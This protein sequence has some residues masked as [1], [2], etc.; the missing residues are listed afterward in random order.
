M[1]GPGDAHSMAP[2][3]RPLHWLLLTLAFCVSLSLASLS[4]A[5]QS[6]AAGEDTPDRTLEVPHAEK[7]RELVL[8]DSILQFRFNAPTS[9]AVLPQTA[10]STTA[11]TPP[12][13][14]TA[15]VYGD[16]LVEDLVLSP[17]VLAVTVDGHV[18]AIKRETGQWVWTLH[19]DGGAALGGVTKQ[20]REQ[21]LRGGAVGGPLVKSVGRKRNNSTLNPALSLSSDETDLLQVKLDQMKEEIYVIEPHSA[22]DIYLYTPPPTT[23]PPTAGTLQKLPLSM[24]QLVSLSP[25]TFPSDSSRMFVGRKETKLVGVDLRS[26]RLVGVFGSGEGWCEWDEQREGRV[27]TEEESDEDIFR[28]PEDLLY[29]A[30]TGA[31]LILFVRGDEN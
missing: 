19:D 13:T 22:G 1:D 23:I 20:E 21:R 12:S 18:H 28:R 7:R 5:S 17:L 2:I 25:F 9:P 10:S 15:N 14:N 6:L 4:A 8:P 11:A 16:P 29:M 30:R 3:T 27:K 24:T 31:S 26:G